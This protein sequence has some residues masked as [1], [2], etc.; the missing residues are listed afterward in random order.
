[1]RS[2]RTGF[3]QVTAVFNDKS[4]IYF[5]RQQVNERLGDFTGEEPLPIGEFRRR[6]GDAD[7]RDGLEFAQAVAERDGLGEPKIELAGAGVAG[8][9]VGLGARFERGIGLEARLLDPPPGGLGS[10]L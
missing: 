9:E 2:P 7:A 10:E 4:N 3:A 6:R 5:A 1:M 8:E